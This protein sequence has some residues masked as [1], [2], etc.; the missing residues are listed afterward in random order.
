[1]HAGNAPLHRML[2]VDDDRDICECLEQFFCSH[3]FSVIFAFSGEQALDQLTTTDVE[4]IILDIL[5]PGLSGLEVLRRAKELCPAARIVIMTGLPEPE[6][7]WKAHAYGA[8]GFVTKPFDF[9]ETTWASA[10]S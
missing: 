5:L 4:V 1:M 9:S 10:L 3:G 6:L 2:I 8:C 7:R